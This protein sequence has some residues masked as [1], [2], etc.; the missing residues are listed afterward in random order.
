MILSSLGS[1]VL[2]SRAVIDAV[3]GAFLTLTI[4]SAVLMVLIMGLVVVFLV[5][6]HHTRHPKPAHIHGNNKLEIFWTIAPTLLAVWMFFIGYSGFKLMR[7]VPKDAYQVD[8]TAQQWAFSFSHPTQG[9]ITDSKLVVPVNTPVKCNLTS[10]IDDVLHSF[11]IPHFRTKED[12]VPGHKTYMWF[13]ADEI[14]SEVKDGAIQP[15]SGKSAHNIFCAEFCGKDHSRMIT[16]LHVL[17]AADFAK[18][19]DGKLQQMYRPIKLDE[20]SQVMDPQS[21]GIKASGAPQLFA[22]YCASCHGANG[23]GGLIENARSFKIDPAAKWKRGVKITDI[24]RTLTL[25]LDGTRMNSFDN[26]PAWDRFAL[27]HHVASLYK[28]GPSRAQASEAEVKALVTEFKLDEQKK[29]T[30]EFP[31]EEAIRELATGE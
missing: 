12:C 17:S 16:K 13:S 11:Y 24:F 31:I 22:T 23:E 2:A 19:L 26:L 14:T 10:K 27:A 15:L 20:L 6:Y 29:V 25:G 9:G 7:D 1:P 4:I 28:D 3:D 18:Y 5:K 8:V 30:R 21:D